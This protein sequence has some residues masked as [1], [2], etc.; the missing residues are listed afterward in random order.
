[1]ARVLMLYIV[2]LPLS[3]QLF[4]PLGLVQSGTICYSG[5]QSAEKDM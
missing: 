5:N 3:L 2:V 1:M 4:N